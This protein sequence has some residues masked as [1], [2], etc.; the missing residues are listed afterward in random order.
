MPYSHL[1]VHQATANFQALLGL[2]EWPNY[3][4]ED[5][6]K[7]RKRFKLTQ[8]DFGKLLGVSYKTILRWEGDDDVIPPTANIALCVLDKLGSDIFMLMNKDFHRFRLEPVDSPRCETTL[9][10][11]T[12]Q[13]SQPDDFDGETIKM[14]R[15][16]LNLSR[17]DFACLLGVSLSTTDKWECGAVKP[18]GPALLILQILWKDGQEALSP[19]NNKD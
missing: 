18:K 7:L 19:T 13:A 8:K 11:R 14:L 12:L 10:A 5:L 16:R 15:Q 3:R 6:L 2:A 17:K 1:D 4:S 9:K